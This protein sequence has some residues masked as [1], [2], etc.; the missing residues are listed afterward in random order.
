MKSM[1]IDIWVKMSSVSKISYSANIDRKAR[2]Q[3]T[4]AA[5]HGEHR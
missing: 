3:D 4:H 5:V 1:Y 2:K